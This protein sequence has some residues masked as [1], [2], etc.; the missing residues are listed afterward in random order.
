MLQI[1]VRQA[2]RKEVFRIRQRETHSI[3][4]AEEVISNLKPGSNHYAGLHR[5]HDIHAKDAIFF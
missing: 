2:R 4:A 5:S 1:R 3:G